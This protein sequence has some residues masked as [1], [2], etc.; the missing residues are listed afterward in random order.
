[1]VKKPLILASSSPYRRELLLKLGVDFAC[2]APDIDE[3]PRPHESPEH[4]VARLALEKARAVARCNR[5][6]LIIASDQVALLGGRI[7]GKPGT[8][9]AARQ[10][11]A[12]ASGNTVLFL[13]SLV[14]LDAATDKFQSAVVPFSVHFRSLAESEIEGYLHKEQPYNCVGAF[15]S[16]GLGITLF[17]RLEGDDPNTLVGL[18]LIQLT[19]M[20]AQAGVRLY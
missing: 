18:P 7:L 4:L 13:T 11:L 12:A 20:L 6:A 1:M 10:Q 3:T 14:L 15:K 16:E 9:A 19:R 17:E 8:H 5:D 2:V